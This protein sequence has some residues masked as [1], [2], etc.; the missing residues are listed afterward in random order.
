MRKA[1]AK[2]GTTAKFD[3]SSRK[4]AKSFSVAAKAY[5]QSAVKSKASAIRTLKREGILTPS[6]QLS[7][8]YA[9]KA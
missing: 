6:G 1:S 4:A 5:T 9:V 7:K 2:N 8:R 3:L